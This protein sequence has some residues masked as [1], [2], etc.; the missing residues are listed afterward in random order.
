VERT[1]SREVPLTFATGGL[2]GSS[3]VK[4]TQVVAYSQ[5]R[6]TVSSDVRGAARPRKILEASC[7]ESRRSLRLLS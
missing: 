6:S 4:E 7:L 3:C 5:R 1:L 2:A